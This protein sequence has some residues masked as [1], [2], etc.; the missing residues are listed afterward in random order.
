M[1]LIY[2]FFGVSLLFAPGT[3]GQ[4]IA[5]TPDA[6]ARE[7]DAILDDEKFENAFWG[8]KVVNLRTGETIYRR[9]D[10]KSFTPASNTKLYTTAAALDLLGPDYRYRT[11]VYVDGHVE[12]S[13]LFGNLIVR[14]S[15][16][17]T[18]G[19]HYDVKTGKWEAEI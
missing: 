2:L 10:R 4:P 12:D 7:L 14:G 9:N 3:I 11:Q 13:L 17:P 15:A 1:R 18:I 19:G 16:A 5:R 8:L 6:L